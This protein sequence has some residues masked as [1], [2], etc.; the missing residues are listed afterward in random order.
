MIQPYCL[1][2]GNAGRWKEEGVMADGGAIDWRNRPASPAG[3][4]PCRGKGTPRL[5]KVT[6]IP[7]IVQGASGHDCRLMTIDIHRPL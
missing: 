7:V 6:A 3:F 4:D 1:Q 2:F 5:L